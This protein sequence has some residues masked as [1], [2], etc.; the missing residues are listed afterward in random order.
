MKM[1]PG[2]GGRRHT[3]KEIEDYLV[4]SCKPPIE[5]ITIKKKTRPDRWDWLKMRAKKALDPRYWW[6]PRRDEIL[7][8][9]VRHVD[10]QVMLRMIE[11]QHRAERVAAEAAGELAEEMAA[12]KRKKKKAAATRA[13]LKRNAQIADSAESVEAA[14]AVGSPAAGTPAGRLGAAS[15][16]RLSPKSLKSSN[17][18]VG[19]GNASEN[20]DSI[21]ASVLNPQRSQFIH[22]R[23]DGEILANGLGL[24][25]APFPRTMG[26]KAHDSIVSIPIMKK[27]DAENEAEEKR[28]RE[29]DEYRKRMLRGQV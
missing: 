3:L 16:N 6:N 25:K 21:G 8:E 11:E 5:R 27:Q 23:G 10:P 28:R 12:E 18:S 26:N 9:D 19:S 24:I 17:I 7:P 1:T 29:E 2:L 22:N 13:A 4:T 15:P 14:E 20:L